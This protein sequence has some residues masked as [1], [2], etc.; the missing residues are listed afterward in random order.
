MDFIIKR[1]TFIS[2]IFIGLSMLGFISYKNL[3][4][5]LLPSVEL[6]SL[7]V[8][9]SS[10][11]EVDPTYMEGQ[12]IIPLEGA[13]GT[14]ED[15]EE[16]QSF[17]QNRQ[18]II[19]VSYAQNA[20][21]K[22]AYLKLQEKIDAIKADLPEEFTV[23]VQKVDIQ[24]LT[25]QFMSLQVRGSGGTDRIRNVTDEEIKSELENIDGVAAANVFGGREKSVEIILDPN[26]YTSYGVTPF[27]IRNAIVQN[28]IDKLYAGR[29]YD[30][31][32]RFFVNI[33]AEYS[34]LNDISEIKISQ[35]A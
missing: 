7:V 16:L 24:Q 3:P 14:L 27:Q 19:Y 29:V 32:R 23:F 31:D 22:Y 2:M 18:G 15:I 34:N 6:P 30:L 33:T 21:M 17:A 9:V 10:R 1:K 25:N 5:E 12:A 4:V 13:I 35:N 26:A 11:L 20:N 8:Q 28:G